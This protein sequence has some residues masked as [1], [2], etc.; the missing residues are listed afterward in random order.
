MSG[1]KGKN[2][3]LVSRAGRR[4]AHDYGASLS[5]FSW[6]GNF[7]VVTGAQVAGV[8]MRVA[9]RSMAALLG[10][11]VWTHKLKCHSKF[12]IETLISA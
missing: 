2:C 9:A 5:V 6:H 4:L 11:H 7:A 10:L 8:Q 12:S 1:G 3:N